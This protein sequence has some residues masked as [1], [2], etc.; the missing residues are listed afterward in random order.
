MYSG[1]PKS[2]YV[3][4]IIVQQCILAHLNK[5]QVRPEQSS[6]ELMPRR[7]TRRPTKCFL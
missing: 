3:H 6:S 4:W 7:G 1:Q 2:K 5:A